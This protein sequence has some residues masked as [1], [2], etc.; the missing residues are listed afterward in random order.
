MVI[1]LETL[2][3]KRIF[4]MHNLHTYALFYLLRKNFWT[5]PK[6]NIFLRFKN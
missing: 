2:S 3:E 5:Y 6:I 1:L 4:S